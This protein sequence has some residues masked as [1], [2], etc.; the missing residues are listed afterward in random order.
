VITKAFFIGAYQKLLADSELSIFG[1]LESEIL[2]V[3][4]PG[5]FLIGYVKVE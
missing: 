3:E 4:T 1:Y 5:F 2:D